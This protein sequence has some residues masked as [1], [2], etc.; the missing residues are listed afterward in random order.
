[1]VFEAGEIICRGTHDE[2][3]KNCKVYQSL[4]KQ[5]GT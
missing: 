1:L 4:S 5:L 3:S 2:L